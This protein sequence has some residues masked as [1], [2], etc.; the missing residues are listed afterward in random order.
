LGKPVINNLSDNLDGSFT[1][2]GTGLNGISAGAAY[3]DDL[4]MDSNYPLIRFTDPSGN[5]L[6][7]R[8]FNW[9]SSG[10]MTGTNIVSTKFVPPANLPS[11]SS[12]VVVANGVASD[13]Q[14]FYPAD[15]PTVHLAY[16]TNSEPL[17]ANYAPQILGYADD[18]NS[19]IAVVRVAVARNSDGAWYD[20]VSSGWGTTAFDFNRNVL[21]AADVVHSAHTGWLGQ[22][23]ALPAGSYT[24]QAQSVN[25]Y[26]HASPWVS[27]PFTK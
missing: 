7:G 2:T 21:N 8:T 1:L 17:S 3:G 26:N 4:Q 27:V 13:S 11:G 14:V 20:F 10:V 24:A 15:F 16:P 12:F 23:P 18:T 5:V 25:A 22:L 9:T 6:Y 19:T